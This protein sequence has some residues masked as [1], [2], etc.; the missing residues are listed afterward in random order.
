MVIIDIVLVINSILGR[1]T[2]DPGGMHCP[3][4]DDA[5][6][7]SFCLSWS[8]YGALYVRG[9][10]VR[11]RIALPIS[12]RFSACSFSLFFIVIIVIIEKRYFYITVAF[13]RVR[14]FLGSG[15][16]LRVVLPCFFIF[17]ALCH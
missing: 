9:C 2:V 16:V 13:R 11:T 17:L 6:V 1:L 5:F 7:S 8:E 12:T 10:I 4:W 15:V 14:T 3:S